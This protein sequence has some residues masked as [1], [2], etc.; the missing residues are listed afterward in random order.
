MTAEFVNATKWQNPQSLSCQAN[1]LSDHKWS[2]VT[3]WKLSFTLKCIIIYI[4]WVIVSQLHSDSSPG[5]RWEEKGKGRGKLKRQPIRIEENDEE[6]QWRYKIR[7][8]AVDKFHRS[9]S[10]HTWM[11]L[12]AREWEFRRRE[13][14]VGGRTVCFLAR[15]PLPADDYLWKRTLGRQKAK[16]RERTTNGRGEIKIAYKFRRTTPGILRSRSILRVSCNARTRF[17]SPAVRQSIA[18]NSQSHKESICMPAICDSAGGKGRE[19]WPSR[20]SF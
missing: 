7:G 18:T 14:P 4:A 5:T 3:W 20:P 6:R 19:T 10:K 16:R 2:L 11:V 15:S 17:Q 9:D 13:I 1:R 8:K 12:E